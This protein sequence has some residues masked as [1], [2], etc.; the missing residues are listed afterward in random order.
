[1]RLD[2]LTSAGVYA[3]MLREGAR[4]LRA[5]IENLDVRP[6]ADG[7]TV[8]FA[9]TGDGALLDRL[10]VWGA[11]FEDIEPEP[12]L[13]PDA[14]EDDARTLPQ[15]RE[16]VPVIDIS[17]ITELLPGVPQGMAGLMR[18]LCAA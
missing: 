4:I 3:P 9:F 6:A 10:A 13:E 2:E 7:N 16:A 12:D 5:I 8:R 17:A 18:D 11:G 14:P 1:M 15:L